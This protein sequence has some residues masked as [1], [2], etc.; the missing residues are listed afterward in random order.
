MFV[1]MYLLVSAIVSLIA[2]GQMKKP[3]LAKTAAIARGVAAE[4][5]ADEMDSAVHRLLKTLR[6]G[7]TA[8]LPG[9]GSILPGRKWVFRQEKHER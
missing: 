9:L 6:S 1:F 4:T 8:H 2:S 5:A 7:Q 3:D